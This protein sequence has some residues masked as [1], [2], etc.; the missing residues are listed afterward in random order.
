MGRATGSPVALPHSRFARA[1]EAGDAAAASSAYA[2][3][4]TLVA[5]AAGLLKGRAEIEAFWGAGISAGIS[6]AAFEP[7]A[8]ESRGWIAYEVG[9]YRLRLEDEDGVAFDHGSYMAV[10]EL[11]PDGSWQLGAQMLSAD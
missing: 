5:P 2:A 8:F 7:L 9:R 10:L 3:A 4:A 1:L 6:E 11:Q